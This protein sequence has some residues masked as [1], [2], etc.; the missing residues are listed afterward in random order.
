[1]SLLPDPAPSFSDP[2]GLL[3]ACHQRIRGHCDLLQRLP[4]WIAQHGMDATAQDS[5]D[6][7]MRYFDVAAPQH[8]ADEEQ[9]LF[10]LLHT[11]PAL[12][13]RMA[14][15]AAEH[16]T[17][18][19]SWQDLRLRLDA[20]ASGAPEDDLVRHIDRFA[21]AC[22]RHLEIEETEILPVAEQVLDEDQKHR[23]GRAMARRRG[24][25]ADAD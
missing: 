16:R 14:K 17:L 24:V 11:H 13:D 12:N 20:V 19:R 5:I 21:E 7:A 2:I 6:R 18:E 1:L 10:P 9:D 4:D 22:L 25:T 15:L 23:L 8:H 3:S